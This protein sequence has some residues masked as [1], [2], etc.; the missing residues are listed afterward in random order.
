MMSEEKIVRRLEEKIRR[1]LSELKL[2]PWE[3]PVKAETYIAIHAREQYDALL[4]LLDEIRK[5]E[6]EK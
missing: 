1:R 6:E 4:R 3:E 5:D 2:D